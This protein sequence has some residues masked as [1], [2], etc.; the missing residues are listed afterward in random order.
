VV[1]SEHSPVAFYLD[2]RLGQ[3]LRPGES[4]AFFMAPVKFEQHLQDNST[5][6][7]VWLAVLQNYIHDLLGSFRALH[8]TSTPCGGAG[9]THL[10]WSQTWI[11]WWTAYDGGCLDRLLNYPS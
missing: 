7:S 8:A 11:S 2:E 9:N 4:P 5:P 3:Y 6:P 10:L 1:T